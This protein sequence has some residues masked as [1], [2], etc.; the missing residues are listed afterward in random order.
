MNT[1]PYTRGRELPEI[2]ALSIT[3]G[4]APYLAWVADST[5]VD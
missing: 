4:S 1:S 2:L 3:G 5:R